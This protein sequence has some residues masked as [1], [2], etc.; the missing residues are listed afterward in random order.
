MVYVGDLRIGLR[1]LDERLILGVLVSL[2]VIM[3]VVSWFY[4]FWNVNFYML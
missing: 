2:F 4:C 3:N 1:R